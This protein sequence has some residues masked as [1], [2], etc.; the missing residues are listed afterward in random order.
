MKYLEHLSST[1][2]SDALYDLA[3]FTLG[4]EEHLDDVIAGYGIDLD[5]I[6]AWWSSR[7]SWPVS[8][9]GCRATVHRASHSWALRCR[10]R[11]APGA[12]RNTPELPCDQCS[13]D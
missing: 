8:R 12:S 3:A 1:V 11:L 13:T 4:Q 5:V 10:R 9:P 7:I 2:T 6:H